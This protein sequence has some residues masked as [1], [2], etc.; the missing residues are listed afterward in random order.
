MLSTSGAHMTANATISIASI[1]ECMIELSLQ[2]NGLWS[3]GYAGDTF[4]VAWAMRTCLPA[5]ARTDY[6]TAFGDDPFSTQQRLFFSQHNIGTAQSPTIP[7]KNPGLYA[8]TLEGHERSFTYWRK[9]SAARN[10]ARDPA[11]LA[12]S[13]VGR[14]LIYFSGITLAILND[15]DRR[16]LLA[17]LAKERD[18]G[19]IIAFDPNYR[20]VLWPSQEEAKTSIMAAV[21]LSHILLPTFPDE[22]QL[23]GDPNPEATVRRL[24]ANQ[25]VECIVKKGEHPALL[26]YR[27]RASSHQAQPVKNPVDT[28]GA[29]DAFNG[30]YLAARLLGHEPT[31]AVEMAHATAA[32]VVRTRGALL[33]VEEKMT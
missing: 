9:D 3:L 30:A 15:A 8:I 12:R 32:A 27:G 5:S 22:Q 21:E 26:Y 2:Q 33:Q 16:A 18:R 20:K 6:V 17:A 7:N 28:S 13:L 1:G 25:N 23:F 29:G 31:Q 4:N 14:N 19:A 10:L 11:A 24:T